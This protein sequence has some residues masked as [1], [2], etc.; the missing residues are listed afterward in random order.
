M[1]KFK[2]LEGA[3]LPKYATDGSAGLDVKVHSFKKFYNEKN[4]ELEEKAF[5]IVVIKGERH[6]MLGPNCR[7]L[8]GT[9]LVLADMDKNL[10]IQVRGRSGNNL[11]RGFSVLL[12]TVDSD[13]RG[14]I[15]VIIQ[16]NS[17]QYIAIEPGERIAQ[18]VVNEI[19]HINF[20]QVEELSKS[21]R[22]TGGFG[23]TGK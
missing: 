6:L 20:V 8:I 17:Q 16:N 2:I 10:E 12:G 1:V 4:E 23:S 5:P 13:Y 3:E 14:E 19:A 18:L 11:K 22:G 21:E 9:G 7:A 15:G